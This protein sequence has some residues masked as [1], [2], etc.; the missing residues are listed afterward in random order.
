MQFTNHNHR[1]LAWMT[2]A[3]LW[4]GASSVQAALVTFSFTG[5]AGN[6]AAFAPDAQPTGAVVS[7]MTRGP[8]LIANAGAGAFN[9]RGWTTL[10]ARDSDDY[11]AFSITPESGST[12]ELTSFSFDALSSST[13][14]ATWALHSSLDG[15]GASLGTF[16]TG[17]AGNTVVLGNAFHYLTTAVEFRI[18]GFSAGGSTGTGRIDNLSLLGSL[19]RKT[20]AVPEGGF[21]LLLPALVLGGMGWVAHR[22]GRVRCE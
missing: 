19:E 18:F 12:L 4:V 6:E 11:Y 7:D 21:S 5:A 9:S 8:G 1:W 3:A 22:G 14:P 10:S 15:F 16:S 2:A 20:T 13:G 17:A